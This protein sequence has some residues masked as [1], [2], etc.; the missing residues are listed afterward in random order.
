MLSLLA[1]AALLGSA[2]AQQPSNE[3]ISPSG[4]PYDVIPRLGFGT[5]MLDNEKN[6]TEAVAMAMVN[7]YRHFD[8]ATAY[9]NQVAI[10]KG[11]AEGLK[12]TGLNRSEI[13]VSS[14]LWSTRH[15]EKIQ[16]GHEANLQQLGLDY[17]DMALMHFPIGTANGKPEY[18]IATTWKAMEK[19]VPKDNAAVKG[20]A[21]YIGISNFN[22]T[23]VEDLLRVATIKPKVH[24]L[25]LHP[26]LQQTRFVA[27][28]RSVGIPLTAYAPL[29][30]TNPAYRKG[31][32]AG[33]RFM[34]A[35]APL[36]LLQNPVLASIAKE[37][38]CTPAQVSIAWNLKRGILSVHPRASQVAHQIENFEGATNCELETEDMVKIRNIQKT[39]KFRMWDPCPSQL[40]LPCYLGLEGGNES[41]ITTTVRPTEAEEIADVAE[42]GEAEEVE[43]LEQDEKDED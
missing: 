27:F 6:A 21:R 25:E 12:R 42:I 34:K 32:I 8:C 22:V 5:W 18:D 4:G 10:G 35:N 3:D 29:G 19:L 36:P 14:K 16:S 41:N 43:E 40:G 33:G 23:Q 17:L 37:R 24:Q 15:G 9:Q 7:G 26:Y 28:H 39:V 1:F 30:D 13:W 2:A 20:A 11:L 31:G 38:G